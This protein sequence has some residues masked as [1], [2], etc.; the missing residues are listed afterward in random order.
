MSQASDRLV[1]FDGM[2]WAGVVL[3]ALCLGAVSLAHC[4]VQKTE[5]ASMEIR[6]LACPGGQEGQALD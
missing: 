5:R 4:E 1:N 6:I 3:A 2:V